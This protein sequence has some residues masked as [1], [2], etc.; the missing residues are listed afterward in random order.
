MH[1]IH[2]FSGKILN[3]NIYGLVLKRFNFRSIFLFVF[4]Y[5]FLT[6]SFCL[7]FILSFVY[8]VLL[9]SLIKSKFIFWMW[10]PTPACSKAFIF[11]HLRPFRV[12]IESNK[13]H[14]ELLQ[15]DEL[16]RPVNSL[17]HEFKLYLF[18]DTTFIVISSKM[19]QMT[20]KP[21]MWMNTNKK[22]KW[23][24]M[25]FVIAWLWLCILSR[26]HNTN[27]KQFLT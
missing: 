24:I 13:L 7:S 17:M 8:W 10:S 20:Y 23:E 19:K 3:K 6:L 18:F 2:V 1:S 14:R 26:L 25:W 16:V 12:H 15:F 4:F 27:T 9:W 11:C 22:V 5:G 21:A